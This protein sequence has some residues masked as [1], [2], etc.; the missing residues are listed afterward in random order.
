MERKEP[1]GADRPSTR[2]DLHAL[3]C[4]L[5]AKLAEAQARID[6]LA[7]ACR[8]AL[9]LLEARTGAAGGAAGYAAIAKCREALARLEES[10]DT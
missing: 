3:S 8:A 7:D 1:Y 2:D 10:D 9:E 4:R 5:M 6:A